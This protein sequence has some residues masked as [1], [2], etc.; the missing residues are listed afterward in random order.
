MAIVLQ[1]GRCFPRLPVEPLRE[2]RSSLLERQSWKTW[3]IGEAEFDARILR[4]S[5]FVDKTHLNPTE[6]VEVGQSQTCYSFPAHQPFGVKIL[7]KIDWIIQTFLATTSLVVR[8][9][10]FEIFEK[11]PI[12]SRGRHFA[13][14][15]ASRINQVFEIGPP[16]VKVSPLEAV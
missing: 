5:L 6:P 7:P 9:K 14:N 12:C 11:I 16:E 2:A 8:R 3:K 4:L 1:D 15:S 10:F 13:P